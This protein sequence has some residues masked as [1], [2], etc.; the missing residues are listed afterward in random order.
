MNFFKTFRYRKI[1]FILSIIIALVCFGLFFLFYNS[2]TD[3]LELEK[4]RFKGEKEF[5]EGSKVL[6]QLPIVY[7]LWAFSILCWI[8]II[9]NSLIAITYYKKEKN[10]GIMFLKI[11]I[12]TFIFSIIA[13]SFLLSFQPIIDETDIENILYPPNYLAGWLIFLFSVLNA[14]YGLLTFKNYG[15]LNIKGENKENEKEHLLV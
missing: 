2:I 13:I 8:V 10:T 11:N 5:L 9:T 1:F 4:T 14:F 6:P 3:Y 15:Y 7:A 12:V